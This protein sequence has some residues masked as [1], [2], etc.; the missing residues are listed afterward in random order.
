MSRAAIAAGDA[1]DQ[2]VRPSLA[3]WFVD[4]MAAMIMIH[5]RPSQPVIDSASCAGISSSRPFGSVCGMGLKDEAIRRWY[6]TETLG[7]MEKLK[8]AGNQRGR[9]RVSTKDPE[10]GWPLPRKL[11]P[12]LLSRSCNAIDPV[13]RH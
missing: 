13:A 10:K 2:Q 4:Q 5:L 7:K 3:G 12:P 11:P 1:V 8:T 9:K 6:N